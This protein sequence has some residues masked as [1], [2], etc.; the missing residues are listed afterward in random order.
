MRHLHRN[1]TPRSGAL[2]SASVLAL[3][4]TLAPHDAHAQ[5]ATATAATDDSDVVTLKHGGQ[6]RGRLTEMLAGDHATVA[7]VNGENAIIRWD[8][9]ASISRGGVPLKLPE[10]PPPAA[11]KPVTPAPVLAPP[12]PRYLGPQRMEYETDDP[13][14][15]GY[16]VEKHPRLGLLISG[17]ILTGIGV[18]GI[19]AFDAQRDVTGSDRLGFDIVFG[20]LFLGPGLPL[21]IVGLASSRKELVRDDIS[22]IQPIYKALGGQGKAPPVFMGVDV[23]P[24][25][26]N[27]KSLSLG[28]R[29]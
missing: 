3:A 5:T 19:V 29:F 2:V 1:T 6:I 21:L 12:P 10:A 7:M 20:S 9:I 16:H 13:V 4:L 14:P 22:L 28:F 23:L 25:H 24:N 11:A 27:H 8:E 18:L 26:Q 15:A 17:S